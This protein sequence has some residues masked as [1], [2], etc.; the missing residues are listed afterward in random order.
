MKTHLNCPCGESIVGTDED[1]L[2]EKTQQHL[3]ANHPGHE[4]SRDE[5]L[6]I[7]Y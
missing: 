4:Y 7:A 6:F 1:D 2:V 5:I 3:T